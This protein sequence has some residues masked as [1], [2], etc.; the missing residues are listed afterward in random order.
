M[1]EADGA[2]GDLAAPLVDDLERG[3]GPIAAPAGGS[4]PKAVT[5]A[6]AGTGRIRS[7][8]SVVKV[9]ASGSVSSVTPATTSTMK[10]T[11][12]IRRTPWCSS[13]SCG[14]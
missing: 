11:T 9:H 8:R 2:G 4:M 3:R 6:G 13:S 1:G 12:L 5:F 7:V 10:V 14:S